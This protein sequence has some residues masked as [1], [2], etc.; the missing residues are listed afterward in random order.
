M[1]RGWLLRDGQVLAAAEWADEFPDRAKGM[2][3]H[4][5]Y[6]GAMVLPRTRSIHTLGVR[7]PLD[8]AFLDTDLVVVDT[9]LVR[10]WRLTLPRRS[11]R[12]VLEA[13]GGAFERWHLAK[14]D[15]LEFRE[16]T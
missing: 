5:G 4:R 3:G 1:L 14:G 2:L 11:G 7:F 16:A 12:N 10:P 9:C 15:R 13:E 8:V 6:E